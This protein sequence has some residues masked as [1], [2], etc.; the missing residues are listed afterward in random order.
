[1]QRVPVVASVTLGATLCG[2]LSLLAACNAPARALGREARVQQEPDP[3][4]AYAQLTGPGFPLDWQPGQVLLHGYAGAKYLSDFRVESGSSSVELD[5]DE[6]EVLPV[7]GGGAQWKLAGGGFDLGLEGLL[8]I[9]GRSDLEAFASGDGG[10]VVV[11]D[12]DLYLIEVYG[13]PFVSRF[14][15]DTV[16]LYGGAGPLLQWAGYDQS[17][18][19]TDEDTDG[20]GGGVYA[21]AGIEFLLPSRRLVG[22]GVRWSESSVDLGGDFGELDLEGLDVFFSYSYGQQP[23]SPFTWD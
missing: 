5:D 22:L 16:R 21:R 8:S 6:Y 15:G 1:M 19:T 12:V 20:S 2:A 3:L 9:S 23:R 4:A 18:D 13:G 7:V 10:A 14:L 17:D 11:F